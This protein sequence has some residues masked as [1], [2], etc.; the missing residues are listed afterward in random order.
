MS[1]NG[2]IIKI[3]I[4]NSH[5]EDEQSIIVNNINPNFACET[6]NFEVIL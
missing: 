5:P 3:N 6:N 4:K 1:N 2:S